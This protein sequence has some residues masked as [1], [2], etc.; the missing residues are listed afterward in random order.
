M[1]VT[2]TTSTSPLPVLSFHLHVRLR[3]QLELRLRLTWH[4]CHHITRSSQFKSTA[5]I[6]ITIM[7]IS[8]ATPVLRSHCVQARRKLVAR[9]DI[10]K[11]HVALY[12]ARYNVRK[13]ERCRYELVRL[14]I[15]VDTQLQQRLE[16]IPLRH[17]HAKRAVVL[18][19]KPCIERKTHA[20]D[21]IAMK[22]RKKNPKRT[23]SA[24]HISDR[25]AQRFGG[26]CA[27]RKGTQRPA[28]VAV[29]SM[30]K[31]SASTMDHAPV[32]APTLART[33]TFRVQ[34]DT[35]VAVAAASVAVSAADESGQVLA[36][37]SASAS[38][39]ASALAS[40]LAMNTPQLLLSSLPSLRCTLVITNIVTYA[41]TKP[42][43]LAW[44]TTYL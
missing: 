1:V 11:L 33:R 20:T 39:F 25:L 36:S 29:E 26:C 2:T 13:A 34:T 19:T 32:P 40:V 27:E 37:A 12:Q 42:H 18:H 44:H 31:T 41:L 28:A 3:P 38:A 43:I 14:E 15:G 4:A 6:A 30:P 8:C 35:T 9:R 5:S 10:E 17:L 21:V 16:R 7:Y 23:Y 22:L 24:D